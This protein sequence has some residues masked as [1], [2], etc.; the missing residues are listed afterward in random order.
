[1]N[2]VLSASPTGADVAC[3]RCG[4]PSPTPLCTLCARECPDCSAVLVGGVACTHPG[5]TACADCGT[6]LGA[7]ESCTHSALDEGLE[8]LAVQL[9]RVEVLAEVA[10]HAVR[11]QATIYET[12]NGFA[13]DCRCGWTTTHRT[14][15]GMLK[16]HDVHRSAATGAA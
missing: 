2:T 14:A 9:S 16:A 15:D 11:H 5:F 10:L 6:M 4:D 12:S 7:G 3:T 1:M 13:C 8:R